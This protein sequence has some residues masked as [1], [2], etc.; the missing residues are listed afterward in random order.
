MDQLEAEDFIQKALA[1]KAAQNMP[2]FASH[3]QS[4]QEIYARVFNYK[5]KRARVMVLSHSHKPNIIHI[6]YEIF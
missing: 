6:S 2:I 5:H 3:W 4:E 1:N